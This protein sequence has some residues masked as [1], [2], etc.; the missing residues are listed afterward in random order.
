MQN[1][2]ELHQRLT[3]QGC[4]NGPEVRSHAPGSHGHQGDVYVHPIEKR[5]AVW[6]V[7]TT[8]QSRQVAVGQGEG[9]NHRAEG[10]IR[11]FW[12]ESRT[13]AAR[14]NTFRLF[15][16]DPEILEQVLGPIVEA[17]EEWT[18]THPKHAH[19]RFPAGTYLIQYQLD[20]RTLRRV[21]D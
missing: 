7:E 14:E 8:D 10:K 3:D 6:N 1:V 20:R 18:L 21:Q 4:G 5:P 16:N 13:D 19:H 15:D 2:M 12:P 9:S 17:E 11:V